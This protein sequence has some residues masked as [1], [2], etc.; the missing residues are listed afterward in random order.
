MGGQIKDGNSEAGS[1]TG[2][3]LPVVPAPSNPVPK[4]EGYVDGTPM[5]TGA[6]VSFPDLTG[7]GADATDN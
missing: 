3:S 1:L 6:T 4:G 2:T 5:A 7:A